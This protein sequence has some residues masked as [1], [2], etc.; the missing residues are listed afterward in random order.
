M[1]SI[2]LGYRSGYTKKNGYAGYYKWV[3][4]MQYLDL[5]QN[6]RQR[7][8]ISVNTRRYW[9]NEMSMFGFELG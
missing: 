6:S 3:I 5:C 9:V 4:K 7:N 2:A 1:G 8:C